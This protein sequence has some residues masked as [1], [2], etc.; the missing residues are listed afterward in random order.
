MIAVMA[1]L[2]GKEY[3]EILKEAQILSGVRNWD[4]ETNKIS[5]KEEF[6]RNYAMAE[7]A[8]KN[9]LPEYICFNY[10]RLQSLSFRVHALPKKM[11]GCVIA[12]FYDFPYTRF[13]AYNRHA[14]YAKSGRLYDP[15]AKI[16]VDGV[17]KEIFERGESPMNYSK[18]CFEYLDAKIS[19]ISYSDVDGNYI[20]PSQK[21]KSPLGIKF[22]VVS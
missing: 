2:A 18:R 9:D 21:E 6:S 5:I 17:T 14:L 19:F 12:E 13:C 1:N 4:Q 22:R 15:K 8:V 20:L 3:E 16:G 11:T 7:I 10:P